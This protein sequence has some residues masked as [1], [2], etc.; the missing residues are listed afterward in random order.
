MKKQLLIL[1]FFTS[2]LAFSQT[3]VALSGSIV[4]NTPNHTSNVAANLIDGD[5]SSGSRY[6]VR[7]QESA[8]DGGTGYP[9]PLLAD[10]TTYTGNDGANVFIEIELDK[11]YTVSSFKTYEAGTEDSSDD[12]ML[13]YKFMV[14]SNSSWVTVVD[15]DHTESAAISSLMYEN[16]DGT[17]TV[18]ITESFDP[19]STSKVRLEIEKHARFK[20]KDDG[21]GEVKVDY[22]R[23]YE[24]EV[25]EAATASTEDNLLNAFSIYP[26][27]VDKDILNI[28]TQSEIKSVTVYNILGKQVKTSN[29]NNQVDVSQLDA[30]VY[31]VRVNN[32]TTKKFIKL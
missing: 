6:L 1:S 14:W 4:A 5:F 17:N 19:V 30:G 29:T 25:F 20:L 9:L 24:L 8:T 16:T 13:K 7:F 28:K 27:P 11:E 3:N 18:T 31:F 12:T 32:S 2:V 10:G 23:M 15:K 26:N 22:I 21:S